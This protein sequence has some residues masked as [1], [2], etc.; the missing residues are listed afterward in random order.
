MPSFFGYLVTRNPVKSLIHIATLGQADSLVR[1]A[2]GGQWLDL[3][4]LWDGASSSVLAAPRWLMA[5]CPAAGALQATLQA[6]GAQLLS[7][8]A[9]TPNLIKIPDLL[10]MGAGYCVFVTDAMVLA[11][12]SAFLSSRLTRGG[13]E[14]VSSNIKALLNF[15]QVMVDI[16]KI[17]VLLGV[18]IFALPCVTGFVVYLCWNSFLFGYKTDVLLDFCINNV[19]GAISVLWGMGISFMLYS[20]IAILQLREILHPSFLARFIRPQESQSDLLT[21]LLQDKTPT[22][23]KRL[24]LSFLVYAMLIGI[25]VFLPLLCIKTIG[26]GLL[27]LCAPLGEYWTSQRIGAVVLQAA[28]L[29][30]HYLAPEVQIPLEVGLLHMTFLMLL[31]KFK[32]VIGFVEFRVLVFLSK[33]LKLNRFLL[34][35]TYKKLAPLSDEVKCF[36]DLPRTMKLMYA[37]REVVE[38]DGWVAVVCSEPMMRPPAGW[39]ARVR[40][41][42]TRWAWTEDAIF[43]LEKSVLPPV[44]PGRL[45]LAAGASIDAIARDGAADSNST[46]GIWSHAHR[47]AVTCMEHPNFCFRL[48]LL[49]LVCWLLGVVGS[50]IPAVL[51]FALGRTILFAFRLPTV[52]CHDPLAYLVGNFALQKV[53]NL[54]ERLHVSMYGRWATVAWNWQWQRFLP[55]LDGEDAAVARARCTARGEG[56]KKTGWNLARE[57]T[58]TVCVGCFLL[59]LC[60]GLI[61]NAFLQFRP[62][63]LVAAVRAWFGASGSCLLAVPAPLVPDFVSL[64][65]HAAVH[66]AGDGTYKF[67]LLKELTRTVLLG[68]LVMAVFV[69]LVLSRRLKSLFARVGVAVLRA[70]V[71]GPPTMAEE[72]EQ[73]QEAARARRAG[74]SPMHWYRTVGDD[75]SFTELVKKFEWEVDCFIAVFVRSSPG[76]VVQDHLELP[77]PLRTAVTTLT[78]DQFLHLSTEMMRT[79]N[80]AFLLSPHARW[81]MQMVLCYHCLALIPLV[82]RA[83]VGG[84]VALCIAA[85]DTAGWFSLEL[86][87]LLPLLAVHSLWVWTDNAVDADKH[88]RR[89]VVRAVQYVHRAVKDDCYLIGKELHN[90]VE[91]S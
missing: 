64:L 10:V 16:V 31:E 78:P 75:C 29:R 17:G 35:Y 73:E 28:E 39:D 87:V 5:L 67:T 6:E 9:A 83:H 82:L 40:E 13:G 65:A 23:V 38:V 20:T 72:Q 7:R 50:F 68:Q 15:V 27:D 32:D 84:A 76:T 46:S 4:D 88:V 45:P 3:T 22:Q 18:R 44:F 60:I 61:F 80:E 25:F 55:P 59:P 79:F 70:D 66:G 58:V 26:G 14:A 37:G 33:K 42:I 51:P 54:F 34:P 30:V 57:L 48:L 69:A 74:L 24:M 63:S 86:N 85:D 71:E 43:P 11:Y 90:S 49:V 77:R 56:E 36:E 1:L 12:L 8:A 41:S 53:F 21:S 89:G 2:S 47:W 52:F 19:V 91:V 81:L 62:L